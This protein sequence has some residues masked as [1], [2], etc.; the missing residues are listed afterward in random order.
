M[1]DVM[2]WSWIVVALTVPTAVALALAFPFWLKGATDSIG[3]IL[4]GAVVFAAG[5]A[6]M[7]REYI[8]VQRVTDACIQAER[9]CSFRPEPF[10]R[11]CLYGFIALLE[12]FALFA[13]GLAVEERMRRRS[14][15][16]EWQA[17][18]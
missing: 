2:H 5:L 16:R 13:L 4:G 10:T 14:Y 9:V 12:A 3:S 7:G 11:F 17:R 6:M 18:S 1:T 15:A 8:H